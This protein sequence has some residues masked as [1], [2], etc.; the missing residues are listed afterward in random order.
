M[1]LIGEPFLS[2]WL[3]KPLF[4]TRFMVKVLLSILCLA[5]QISPKCQHNYFHLAKLEA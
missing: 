2:F 4:L 5:V 3:E 1:L